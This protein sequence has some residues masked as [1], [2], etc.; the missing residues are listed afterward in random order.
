M[1]MKQSLCSTSIVEIEYAADDIFE[2]SMNPA[3]Q[4]G[5]ADD[6]ESESEE[7]PN[8]PISKEK[9]LILKLVDD[10]EW[11]KVM[12]A[13]I[14]NKEL[15]QTSLTA[16]SGDL[17]LHYVCKRNAPLPV[18][19]SILKTNE[20]A[21]SIPG[22][23]GFLPLH[24]AC[25]NGAPITLIELLVDAYPG[26]V[27]VRDNKKSR[28]P[29]HLVARRDGDE[30]AEVLALL[31][32]YF[33]E[34]TISE[35]INGLR[36]L[37]YAANSSNHSSKARWEII[38]VLEMG[39]KWIRVGENVTH[40]LEQDFAERLRTLEKDLGGYVESLKAVHD[41]DIGRIANDMLELEL[42]SDTMADEVESTIQCKLDEHVEKYEKYLDL[43]EESRA[44]R[45]ELQ[46]STGIE[47]V[48]SQD[49]FDNI[50][51][52]DSFE[53]ASLHGQAAEKSKAIITRED[54]LLNKISTLK[55]SDRLK[56][57]II[58]RILRI[59]KE[60]EKKSQK[61][62]KDLV[63]FINEQ[64]SHIAMLMTKLDLCEEQLALL[65]GNLRS[66]SKA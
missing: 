49:Q 27:K 55:K 4:S 1:A 9:A 13:L 30:T 28:L 20:K 7:T 54:E 29:L 57:G 15:T 62:I 2:I 32:S 35:D 50:E 43:Q 60:R 63:S 61:D 25:A 36:P 44:V 17:L 51:D 56:A 45:L 5:G 10:Q 47:Y 39:Q 31:M 22:N 33:P 19:R 46:D 42:D 18:I 21:I 11:A 23:N 38:S 34:A 66:L 14:W 8:S 64:Q 3:Y 41:E 65:K 58:K 48:F 26:A 6:T 40:R 24:Y 59:A 37:D 12:E 16:S 53:W 52:N